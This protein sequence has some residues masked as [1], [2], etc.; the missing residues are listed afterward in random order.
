MGSRPGEH[1]VSYAKEHGA[2]MIIMASGEHGRVARFL[3]GSVADYVVRA[4]TCP[5]LIV[6]THARDAAGEASLVSAA[7]ET[8]WRQ[9][10]EAR[11]VP[12]GA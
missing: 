3:L 2:G 4:A 7:R 10:S 12:S 5:V 1:I 8:R 6:P 11:K 9:A